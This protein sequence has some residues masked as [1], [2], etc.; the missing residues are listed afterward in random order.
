MKHTIFYVAVNNCFHKLYIL[1]N[2]KSKEQ[3][4][5]HNAEIPT[6]SRIKI[7]IIFRIIS[8][9]KENL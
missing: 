4:Y 8:E 6:V 7:T 9:K 2:H 3:I 5:L 1:S